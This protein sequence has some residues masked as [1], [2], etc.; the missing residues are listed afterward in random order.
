MTFRTLNLSSLTS[1]LHRTRSIMTASN[2]SILSPDITYHPSST[3]DGNGSISPIVHCFFDNSTSTWTYIVSDPAT[4]EALVIDPVLEYDPASGSIGTD[5]VSGLKDFIDHQGYKI[6]KIIETHVHADHATGARV[7]KNVSSP[8]N[9]SS[10]ANETQILSTAPP[11]YI[12]EDVRSVQQ[13]FAPIYGMSQNDFDGSFDEYLRDGDKFH[14]GSL[15]VTIYGLP[16]HTPDSIGIL[17]SDSLFAGDS[18]F[19]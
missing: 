18:I 10:G 16:G 6:S 4:R 13:A 9:A 8:T 12:G 19:A 2:P 1:T 11:I 5:S 3:I 14:L 15:D 7:L 17:V